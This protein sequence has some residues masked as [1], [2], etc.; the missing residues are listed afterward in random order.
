M[1]YKQGKNLNYDPQ[2]VFD[3]KKP[4]L[5]FLPRSNVSSRYIFSVN[6]QFFAYPQNYNHYVK[7]YRNTIQHGGISMHEMLIPFVRLATV[8]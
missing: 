7:Y 6:D 5:A 1:R 3:I 4:E 2:K 8:G